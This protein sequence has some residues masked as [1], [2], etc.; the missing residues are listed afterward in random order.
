MLRSILLASTL[1]FGLA[2]SSLAQDKARDDLPPPAPAAAA[3]AAP[4]GGGIQG[5]NI[6]EVKPEIRPDASSDP[7]YMQQGNAER[8]RVQPGNN[9]PIWRGVAAGAEGFTSI[10]KSQ[11]PEA[12][13]LIQAP[14]QY[15]GSRLTTAGE[16]WRQVRNVWL[17]PYGGALFL[18][19]LGALA[20]FYFT[21]GPI[22]EHDSTDGVRRIERFTPFERS[23]HWANA[24][25]FCVLAISG[26]VMAFG[27]F[28]M[29]PVMGGALFG[30]LTWLL[31]TMHNFAGPLF[32]VSLLIM[33]FTF[34]R[35]NW[36]ERGDMAWILKG[37]GLFSK[38]GEEAPPSNRYNPGEK[39]VFW[40]GVLL[41]G[42]VVVGSGLVMDKLLPGILYDRGTM[43]VAHMVHY[44]STILM[45]CMFAG[46]I[47]LGTVGTRGA[48]KAMRTGYV[49]DDW[50]REH[51]GRWYEDIQ[52]GKVPAQ[53]SR[54]VPAADTPILGE[55]RA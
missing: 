13:V 23:T 33:F 12:G 1:A 48:Y 9:A 11:D 55:Q 14:V 25:A 35:D 46:H 3:P 4:Q 47:Y 7:K 31:K 54:P 18:I 2:A 6:F 20:L 8:N 38:A 17:I 26:I 19:V 41:L 32:A 30:W 37:G 28:F 27:K 44:V 36:P 29:L 45:M 53:R 22:G 24:I 39:F 50:A 5:Q 43:Q 40:I 16:A 15:P 52:A 10:P 51:H 21:K 42:S 34:L 49:G